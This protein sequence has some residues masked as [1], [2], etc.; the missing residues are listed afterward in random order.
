MSIIS[1]KL[2]N[3]KSN[4]LKIIS[5]LKKPPILVFLI[6]IF[7]VIFGPWLAPYDPLEPKPM[8]T[9]AP[10]SFDH[11]FGTDNYGFDVFSRVLC[12]ARIDFSLALIGVI[13]GG[14]IGS[15]LG[16]T[17]AYKGGIIDFILLRFVEVVQ[18]FPVLLF[19]L[20]LFAAIGGGS[21]NMV[22]AIAIVNIPMYLRIVRSSL[23]PLRTAE[24]VDAARCAGLKGISIIVKHFIPNAKGQIFSLFVLSC[25]YAIQIIAGL[26]FIGLGVEPPHPE[27]GSMINTGAGYI[28]MGVWWPS[29]FPGLAIVFSVYA[30][31]GLSR[32]QMT[33]QIRSSI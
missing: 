4:L 32:H 21:R 31:N 22:L 28:M 7:V 30:I 16:A 13:I 33:G 10:P 12:A 18:S 24:F 11:W 17:A 19:A 2:L 20:A 25:A 5:L 23:L 14:G 9:L 1:G 27:W 15:L 26:S 8:N 29:V 6:M 3:K